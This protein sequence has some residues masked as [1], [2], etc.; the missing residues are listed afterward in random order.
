M[1]TRDV[2]DGKTKLET[3]PA[4][5]P[6]TLAQI[7]THL[8]L[9][10]GDDDDDALR[11][12]K[13]A[14]AAVEAHLQQALFKQT[15]SMQLDAFPCYIRIP[16]LPLIDVTSI[17]YLDSDGALVPLNPS[18]FHVGLRGGTIEPA[19]GKCWP[20]TADLRAAVTVEWTAGFVE[21]PSGDAAET[22]P[23]DLISWKTKAAILLWLDFLYDGGGDKECPP[24]VEA[25]LGARVAV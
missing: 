22:D 12:Y 14:R 23:D 13:A 8:R 21:P 15:L 20:A 7:L 10:S 4:A 3:A 5:E 9:T 16:I 1:Y 25:L 2:W 18:Q 19:L 17:L 11:N 6:H 24:G